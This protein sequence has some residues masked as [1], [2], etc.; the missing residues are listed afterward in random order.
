MNRLAKR[1]AVRAFEVF[2]ALAVILNVL[3]AA[4]AIKRDTWGIAFG[5]ILIAGM[6]A[7]ALAL[8]WYV[9]HRQIPYR[10]RDEGWGLERWRE[11]R[12]GEDPDEEDLE[13]SSWR[14]DDVDDRDRY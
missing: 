12:G 3:A 14:D 9:K 13:D 1:G 8:H 10:W 2:G 7:S 5:Y 11:G 6:L 4:V